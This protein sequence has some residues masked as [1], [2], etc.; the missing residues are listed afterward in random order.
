MVRL[1]IHWVFEPRTLI[2]SEVGSGCLSSTDLSL[3][4]KKLGKYGS[5]LPPV[6]GCRF[7][8]ESKASISWRPGG[9][10]RLALLGL[11]HFRSYMHPYEGDP[12]SCCNINI[13][14][15]AHA[16]GITPHAYSPIFGGVYARETTGSITSRSISV[17]YV[18]GLLGE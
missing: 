16:A 14:S 17:G 11:V 18:K 12:S 7:S 2:M 1:V 6:F 9:G 8:I 10:S 13:A 3:T 4:N 5:R 15:T